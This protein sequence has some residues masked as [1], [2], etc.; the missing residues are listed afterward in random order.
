MKRSHIKY[1]KKSSFFKGLFW[2][3]LKAKEKIEKVKKIMLLKKLHLIALN[4]TIGNIQVSPFNNH[5]FPIKRNL[6]LEIKHVN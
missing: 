1:K 6:R 2:F 3:L 4:I 5:F